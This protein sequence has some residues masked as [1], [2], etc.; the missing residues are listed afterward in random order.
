ML[1]FN[2]S[3]YSTASVLVEGAELMVT[4]ENISPQSRVRV[5]QVV[6]GGG[7]IRLDTAATAAAATAGQSGSLRSCQRLASLH[8][9]VLLEGALM[10]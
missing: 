8:G 4:L 10:R 3:S 1:T 6:E 5:S 2:L 9:K 7:E